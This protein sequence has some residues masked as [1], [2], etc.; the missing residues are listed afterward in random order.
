MAVRYLILKHVSLGYGML[1]KREPNDIGRVF[2]ADD[3]TTKNIVLS[4][5][6][7]SVAENISLSKFVS[8]G[9]FE[10][11]FDA[12]TKQK[13]SDYL[14]GAIKNMHLSENECYGTIMGQKEYSFRIS[15]DTNSFVTLSCSCPV[16]EPCK[17]LYAA[18]LTI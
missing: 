7:L 3:R 11:L 13:A 10:G 14:D 17:H 4:H 9:L 18:F 2:F 1:L 5:P 8:L 12:N 16:N 15:I 6:L